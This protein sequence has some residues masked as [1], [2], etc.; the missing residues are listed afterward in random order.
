MCTKLQR[1]A[2]VAVYRF[3]TSDLPS[4]GLYKPYIHVQQC[5]EDRDG[6]Y[7]FPTFS[8]FIHPLLFIS[9]TLKNVRQKRQTRT[10]TAVLDQQKMEMMET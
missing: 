5:V 10:R 3:G 8:Q 1:C 7:S 9:H 4:Y 2:V 6:E